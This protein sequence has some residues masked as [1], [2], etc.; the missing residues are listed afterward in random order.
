VHPLHA[1]LV[2]YRKYGKGHTLPNF[3]CICQR[4]E[5]LYGAGD[6]EDLVDIMKASRG[7]YWDSDDDIE[8]CLRKPLAV[9]RR[10]DK[11]ARHMTAGGS[12]NDL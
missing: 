11:G 7:W 3:W 9:F 5:D 12:S 4:C 2:G 1:D 10:A 6:D 8:E